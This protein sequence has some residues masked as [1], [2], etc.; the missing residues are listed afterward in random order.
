MALSDKAITLQEC[1]AATGQRDLPKKIGANY[2]KVWIKAI[3]LV[4]KAGGFEEYCLCDNDG[5]NKPSIKRDFGRS[6]AIQEILGIF[7]YQELEGRFTPDLRSD[8][9]ILSFLVKNG[10]KEEEISTLL[11]KEG[12]DPEQV[13]KDRATVKTFVNNIALKL[14][15]NTLAEEQRCKDLKNYKKRIDNGEEE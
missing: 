13:K 6:A 14:A 8:K 7:P 1:L 3:C 5:N 12:K 4:R 15:K 9:A 11:E 10:Y 2:N